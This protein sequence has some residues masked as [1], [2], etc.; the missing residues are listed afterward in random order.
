MSLAVL[1]RKSRRY[2]A[3]ISGRGT[4]GF[5]INGGRRNQG[6]VGQAL[7]GQ[8]LGGTRFRGGEPVGHGGCCGTYKRVVTTPGTCCANDPEIIKPSNMNT[9]GYISSRLTP[10]GPVRDDGTYSSCCPI[11]VQ[12][13]PHRD[14]SEYLRGIKAR[15]AASVVLKNDTGIS[16]CSQN[17]DYPKSRCGAASYWIGGKRFI[18][19][20]YSKNLNPL[21]VAAS[22]YMQAGLMAK[23]DLPTPECKAPFPSPPPPSTDCQPKIITPGEAKAAGLLVADW[24]KCPKCVSSGTTVR[25]PLETLGLRPGLG[26]RDFPREARERVWGQRVVCL[27]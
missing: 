25:L 22:E 21:P 7:M 10:R 19:Q 8:R 9:A 3:P 27:S 4:K 6:W 23:N 12:D 20:P 13:M 2:K 18:R 14:Q 15:H 24:G 11:W 16:T 5:S 1:A 26:L 17:P